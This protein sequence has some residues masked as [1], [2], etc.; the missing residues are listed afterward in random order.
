M[1][2]TGDIC[3]KKHDK[4]MKSGGK[5]ISRNKVMGVQKMKRAKS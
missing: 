1:S 3:L 2:G 5:S 4:E